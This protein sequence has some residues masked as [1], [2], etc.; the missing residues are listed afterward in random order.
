M[1]ESKQNLTLY[2]P[3]EFISLVF[4]TSIGWQRTVAQPPCEEN[5]KM[6]LSELSWTTK[7]NHQQHFF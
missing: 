1:E 6:L 5:I 2:S 3:F 4:T 7:W